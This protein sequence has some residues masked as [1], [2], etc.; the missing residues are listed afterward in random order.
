MKHSSDSSEQ[1]D[2]EGYLLKQL[3]IKLGVNFSGNDS[4]PIEL[5]VKPDAVDLN[6]KIVV[7]VYARLGELK[8]A[9]LHKVKGD[10]LKLV[11][12]DTKLGGGWRK[13]LCFAS[14]A[15]AKYAQ[16]K[17][18]VAEAART[19]DIEIVIINLPEDLQQQIKSAQKR[20][21]MVNAV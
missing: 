13:V 17:S 7:E 18:W 5:G 4:L 14:D 20:Q 9:Q 10:I 16:G 21:K 2:V 12:I 1:Q 6:N 3:E 8:G 11:L 15:A 19:F